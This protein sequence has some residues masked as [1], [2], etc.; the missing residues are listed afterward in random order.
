M[1]EPKWSGRVPPPPDGGGGGGA[2][3]LTDLTDVTGTPG[4]GKAPVYDDTGLAPLTEVITLAKVG[5][6]IWTNMTLGPDFANLGQGY[7]PARYRH[8]T[9]NTVFVEGVVTTGRTIDNNDA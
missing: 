9:A 6:V 2:S 1:P 7:A 4:E 8:T 5:E 3:S